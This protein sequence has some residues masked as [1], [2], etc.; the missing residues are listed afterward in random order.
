MQQQELRQMESIVCCETSKLQ[1]V[2]AQRCLFP[3]KAQVKV[4]E[5]RPH[6]GEIMLFFSKAK[7]NADT[8]C[9]CTVKTPINCVVKAKM[10]VHHIKGNRHWNDST[11]TEVGR[12]LKED[13]SLNHTLPTVHIEN[14]AS[15]WRRSVSA[16]AISHPTEFNRWNGRQV[17]RG[18]Q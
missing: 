8:W 9:L 17:N 3:R 13:F 1:T 16:R 2:K 10:T 5:K 15:S 6:R 7:P 11:G 12:S 18:E 14:A 4:M